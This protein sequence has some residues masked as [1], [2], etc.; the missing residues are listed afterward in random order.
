[1]RLSQRIMAYS[2]SP[3]VFWSLGARDDIHGRSRPVLA[4]EDHAC[5]LL[6]LSQLSEATTALARHDP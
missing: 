4:A 2:G 3:G 1:M 5:A 6:S